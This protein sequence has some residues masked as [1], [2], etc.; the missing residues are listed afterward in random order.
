M[1]MAKIF[2][3]H[4][5]IWQGSCSRRYPADPEEDRR[6][7]RE[8]RIQREIDERIRRQVLGR[9]EETEQTPATKEPG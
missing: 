3:I 1:T 5:L 7:E 6:I 4:E 9:F 2:D 8:K